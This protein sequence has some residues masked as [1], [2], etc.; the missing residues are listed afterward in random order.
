M[1]CIGRLVRRNAHTTVASTRPMN[2]ITRL[3][4]LESTELTTGRWPRYPLRYPAS[5]HSSSLMP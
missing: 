2:G 3:S 4:V 5:S 1:R